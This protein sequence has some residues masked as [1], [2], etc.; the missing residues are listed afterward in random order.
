MAWRATSS[1]ADA[2]W[3]A[4]QTIKTAGGSPRGTLRRRAILSRAELA[5]TGVS[6]STI[7]RKVQRRSRRRQW[8]RRT[9]A[10]LP[11]RGNRRASR[12]DAQN[13][14]SSNF[15]RADGARRFK[16][17]KRKRRTAALRLLGP[18]GPSSARRPR[19]KKARA[20]GRDCLLARR[21]NEAGDGGAF[22]EECG[23]GI[24]SV[25]SAET[26]QQPHNMERKRAFEQR[27]STRGSRSTAGSDEGP[28]AGWLAGGASATGRLPALRAMFNDAMSAKCGQLVTRQT[29]SL[30]S[31]CGRARQPRQGQPPPEELVLG[32]IAA[33]AQVDVA[34]R[35]AWL[36]GRLLHRHATRRL[37][38][39]RC[40]AST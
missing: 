39:L 35:R 16:T 21:A 2:V 27:R 15:P 29:R 22:W 32:L 12:G 11:V 5:R 14:A 31:D 36:T 1:Q 26:V 23:S 18:P 7:D 6:L 19:A 33:A 9:R 13:E 25:R 37:D 4:T 3:K 24:R 28:S 30:N 40:H 20:R 34:E 8:G 10:V 38:A 17:R